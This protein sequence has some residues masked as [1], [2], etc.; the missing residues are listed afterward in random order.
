MSENNPRQL[1]ANA[2][3]AADHEAASVPHPQ[4][5]WF[6]ALDG[7]GRSLAQTQT[8]THTQTQTQSLLQI[9]HAVAADQPAIMALVRS[10][11]LKPTGIHW[12]RFLVLQDQHGGLQGA[13]QMRQHRDGALELGSLVVAPALRGQGLAGRLIGALLSRHEGPVHMVTQAVY[14][15]HFERFGFRRIAPS[16]APR[17]VRLAFRLGRL[18]RVVTFLKGLPPRRLAIFRRAA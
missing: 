8:H 1:A 6:W 2:K 18:G 4:A 16:L 12:Q 3:D 13:V 7:A 5:L 17:S 9:R 11:R 10:E 14:A 15:A